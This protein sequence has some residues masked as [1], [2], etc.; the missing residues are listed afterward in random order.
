MSSVTYDIGDKVRLK[1]KDDVP[2]KSISGIATDPSTVVWKVRPPGGP[3]VTYTYGVD[4]ALVRTGVG[5]YY[6][7]VSI[8]KSGTWWHELIGTGAAE[9]AEQDHFF[10]QPTQ[11]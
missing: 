3:T 7:E 2:I 4:A 10:V 5:V 6:L 9:F 8:T 1:L 11:V